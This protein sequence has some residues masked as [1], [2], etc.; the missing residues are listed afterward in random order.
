[1]PSGYIRARIDCQTPDVSIKYVVDKSSSLASSFSTSKTVNDAYSNYKK[2]GAVTVASLK[3]K[4]LSSTYTNNSIIALGNGDFKTAC[5]Q[6]VAAQATHTTLGSSERGYEG[7][8]QTV[9]KIIDPRQNSTSGYEVYQMEDKYDD[10]N[11]RGTTGWSGEPYISP[12]PLRDA[13]VG[14]PYLRLCYKGKAYPTASDYNKNYF[15]V[16]FALSFMSIKY[17]PVFPPKPPPV[18]VCVTALPP[19]S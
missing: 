2:A 12:F 7:V 6:Y 18:A 5:R 10:F 17:I 3:T 15:S 8:F 11:I 14:S 19:E 16:I 1:M 4:T 9:V 13:Q